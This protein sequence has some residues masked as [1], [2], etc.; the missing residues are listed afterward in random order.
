MREALE[1]VRVESPEGVV[2]GTALEV[3]PDAWS[4]V[5]TGGDEGTE[6]FVLR[7]DI[8][9]L[10]NVQLLKLSDPVGVEPTSP[11]TTARS[12]FRLS[13]SPLPW[14]PDPP[15]Y[16]ADLVVGPYPAGADLE[17]AQRRVP[18]ARVHFTT[19]RA[20]IPDG[21]T[22]IVLDTLGEEV[23]VPLRVADH[24]ATPAVTAEIPLLGDADRLVAEVQ[25]N[26]ARLE[27]VPQRTR[28]L[29]LG[30]EE[31]P[32]TVNRY[33]EGGKLLREGNH[34][35]QL[36]S[37]GA[38]AQLPFSLTIAPGSESVASSLHANGIG[39]MS[40]A[41]AWGDLTS[42]PVEV[43]FALPW[44]LIVAT[45]L[46]GVGGTLARRGRSDVDVPLAEDLF[47]GLFV[48]IVVVAGV[49][50]GLLLLPG[51]SSVVGTGAGAFVIAAAAAYMGRSALHRLAMAVGL[52]GPKP[53]P[54]SAPW[55][56]R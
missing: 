6:E 38:G 34:V 42:E 48:S 55:S 41:V 39:T 2:T 22:S 54:S 36:V 26:L 43:R 19:E 12:W 15:A 24:R 18:A 49:G 21:R 35:F 10:P 47:L 45:T 23:Q 51:G 4:V 9:A 31:L 52:A 5:R 1:P 20:R 50:V 7:E 17:L 27:V 8:Q 28:L 11:L 14:L 13:T 44:L 29:G 40:L 25:P 37:R 46:G 53:G 16:G 32:F 3:F 33:A 56:L 30:L